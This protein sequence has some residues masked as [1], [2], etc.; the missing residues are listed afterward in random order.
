M[1]Y[2]YIYGNSHQVHNWLSALLLVVL[3]N[4]VW[5]CPF[6]FLGVLPLCTDMSFM[7]TLLSLLI[8]ESVSWLSSSKAKLAYQFCVPHGLAQF[9]GM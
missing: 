8:H 9:L 5:E 2:I 1:K 6:P 4:V 3:S 7:F